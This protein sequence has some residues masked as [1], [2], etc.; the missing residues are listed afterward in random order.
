MEKMEYALRLVGV[1]FFIS[2]TIV[3]FTFG[4]L[5]LDNIFSTRPFLLIVGLV[6]GLAMAGFGVYRLLLPLMGGKERKRGR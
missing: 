2:G 1:G 6:F 5:W 4:G 3:L